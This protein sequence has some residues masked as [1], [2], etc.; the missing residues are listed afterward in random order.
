MTPRAELRD[1]LRRIAAASVPHL[2]RDGKIGYLASMISAQSGKEIGAGTVRDLWYSTD[3]DART[4]DSRHMDWA[5]AR[6]RTMS[7]NDNRVGFRAG[8]C[9]PSPPS[10]IAA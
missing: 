7:A 3:D 2:K 5:R 6:S 1:M 4:V 8:D 9:L 10:L